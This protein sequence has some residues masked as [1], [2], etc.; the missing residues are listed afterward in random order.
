MYVL[1]AHD[2]VFRETLY[3][4]A[5]QR[6]SLLQ[7]ALRKSI[8]TTQFVT[9]RFTKEHL[10]DTVCYSTLYEKKIDN[11]VSRVHQEKRWGFLTAQ[12]RYYRYR[13][14]EE[15]VHLDAKSV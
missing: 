4:R 9:A 8:S 1:S 15:S 13:A 7:H 5:S 14:R 11:A 12:V 3:Q 6:Q 10:N 2:A